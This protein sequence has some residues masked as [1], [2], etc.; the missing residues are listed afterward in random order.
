MQISPYHLSHTIHSLPPVPK[1]SSPTFS[2]SS[3][4]RPGA[5][6]AFRRSAMGNAGTRDAAALG[7]GSGL[8]FSLDGTELRAL[9]GGSLRL[10]LL[11][12]LTVTA[13]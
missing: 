2:H 5:P 6:W 10:K 8:S 11:D 9:C 1:Q 4:P 7:P 12:L 13:E 3:L